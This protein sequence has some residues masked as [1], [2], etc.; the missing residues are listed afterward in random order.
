MHS[1]HG[2]SLF[3]I[4]HRKVIKKFEAFDFDILAR[5]LAPTPVETSIFGGIS[6]VPIGCLST[7]V[8]CKQ[9]LSTNYLS[10]LASLMADLPT[11]QSSPSS[12]FASQ[13]RR[14]GYITGSVKLPML[15]API[16][17]VRLRVRAALAL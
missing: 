10:P 4:S 13:I 2:G 8:R 15:L 1:G 16:V 17:S 9:S 11:Y 14:K 12:F 5:C 3:R 6:G 7:K